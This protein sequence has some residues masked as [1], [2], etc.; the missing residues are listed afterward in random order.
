[1]GIFDI[2]FNGKKEHN[3]SEISSK[4]DTL[5]ARLKKLEDVNRESAHSILREVRELKGNSNLR[6]EEIVRRIDSVQE[7]LQMAVEDV[8]V[9]DE[10]MKQM[11]RNC[12]KSGAKTFNEIQKETKASP[13]ALAK[14]LRLMKGEVEEFNGVY[15]IVYSS[16]LI[17]IG[18]GNGGEE[19]GEFAMDITAP[20]AGSDFEP[21]P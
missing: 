19:E 11:V 1:M 13:Q 4:L 8:V 12:L 9:S 7:K 18:K 21:G 16:A 5:T 14:Y 3:G 6:R 20:E 15:R 2:F 10:D 17:Y